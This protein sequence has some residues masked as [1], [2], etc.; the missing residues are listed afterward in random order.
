MTP[1]ALI[2]DERPPRRVQET[3]DAQDDVARCTRTRGKVVVRPV[4]VRSAHCASK[5]AAHVVGRSA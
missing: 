4:I 2:E 1:V 5:R 3:S